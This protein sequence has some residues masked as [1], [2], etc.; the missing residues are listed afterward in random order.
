MALFF[1]VALG[2]LVRG[3]PLDADGWFALTLF[4]NFLPA[5]PVGILDGT[6]SVRAC[7]P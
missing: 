1:G 2:N 4:T 5:D 6:P 3:V 7:S